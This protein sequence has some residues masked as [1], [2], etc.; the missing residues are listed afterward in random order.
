MN[1][2]VP[3]IGLIAF[4]SLVA[5]IVAVLI[6]NKKSNSTSPS[7]S[8]S[9]STSGSTSTS[10]SF[11][12]IYYFSPPP[13]YTPPPS[14]SSN[15][16]FLHFLTTTLVPMIEQATTQEAIMTLIKF[17]LNARD[18]ANA[19]LLKD[20]LMKT[21]VFTR[22]LRGGLL[23]TFPKMGRFLIARAISEEA[24][25]NLSKLGIIAIDTIVKR[26]GGNT[27]QAINDIKAL[28]ATNQDVANA[29]KNAIADAA[30]ETAERGA[31]AS[32]L[33]GANE[34]LMGITI[35]NTIASLMNLGHFQNN[36][37]TGDYLHNKKDL[38]DLMDNYTYFQ[39]YY[40]FPIYWGP[41][42]DKYA[43]DPLFTGS[44]PSPG[45]LLSPFEIDM[46]DN[47]NTFLY[48]E[49]DKLWYN[50]NN[51]P[52]I[53]EVDPIAYKLMAGLIGQTFDGTTLTCPNIS[54]SASSPQVP[55]A[56]IPPP[57]LQEYD[58]TADIAAIT[59]A[60]GLSGDT[61][62][63]AATQYLSL[64]TLQ[65]IFDECDYIYLQTKAYNNLCVI[66]GGIVSNGETGTYGVDGGCS[67]NKSDCLANSSYLPAHPSADYQ[68][69]EWRDLDYFTQLY[70]GRAMKQPIPYY[71]YGGTQLPS[72]DANET[73]QDPPGYCIVR[74]REM[75]ILCEQPITTWAG[76]AKPSYDPST[77]FCQSTKDVCDITNTKY[78]N[79]DTSQLG[80]G[81]P[82]GVQL[83]SQYGGKLWTCGEKPGMDILSILLGGTFISDFIGSAVDT[84]G[85]SIGNYFWDSDM[86]SVS[87]KYEGANAPIG[88]KIGGAFIIAGYE[89]YRFYLA[90]AKLTLIVS[91]N[92]Y[93]TYIHLNKMIYAKV[94]QG[95][96]NGLG[97]GK[98]AKIF[99]CVIGALVVGLANLWFS[100]IIIGPLTVVT[101]IHFIGP[102]IIN[103]MTAAANAIVKAEE[104]VVNGLVTFGNDIANLFD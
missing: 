10:T 33:D 47:V 55:I 34:A 42:D 43:N 73:L 6:L 3:A 45:T 12:P 88:Y 35:V 23:R 53:Y 70:P 74:S 27:T 17:I 31:A 49:I 83:P 79:V 68:Y 54:P 78:M 38:D 97:G 56:Q 66:N 22:A 81:A 30:E 16:Q 18:A 62:L 25:V 37:M 98:A 93:D 80:T 44:S 32:L 69:S 29:F 20:G 65:N 94:S 90:E 77:G 89:V 4:M 63:S 46:I 92:L 28:S 13:P 87:A 48:T 15:Q 75:R 91:N 40:T 72:N 14:L 50:L 99:G 102:A 2:F 100:L 96:S 59:A 26:A 39:N 82:W 58:W 24:L 86:R 85:R 9:T 103:A 61:L 95:I 57:N 101:V 8:T 1:E 104:T 84:H 19:S 64:S 67:Y 51:S 41:L 11:S 21:N 71:P 7:G 52:A 60:T 5:I 36:P 76:S